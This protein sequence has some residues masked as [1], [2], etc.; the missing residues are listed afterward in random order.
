M[1]CGSFFLHYID[2]E[3]QAYCLAH[4]MTEMPFDVWDRDPSR[5]AR[6]ASAM[7]Y[8]HSDPGLQPQHMASSYNFDSLGPSLLFVDIGGSTGH[9]SIMLA[10]KYPNMTCIVQDL[11][12]TVKA[13]REQLPEHLEDRVSFMAHDFWT[14]QPVRGADVYYFRWI[15]HDWSDSLSVR[16]LRQL[17]PALKVGAKVLVND[18]CIPPPG[19]M[20]LYQEQHIRSVQYPLSTLFSSIWGANFVGVCRSLDLT[21]KMFS[22]AKERTAREWE[23]LFTRADPGFKF[24]GVHVPV[25]AKVANIEAHWLPEV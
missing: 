9:V 5:V 1:L 25:G 8:L 16:I 22:N 11:P 19:G 6:F 2:S 21:M 7:E 23:D 12:A 17:V 24:K 20:S 3:N 4:N 14:E 15:F 10:K 13:G 18:I